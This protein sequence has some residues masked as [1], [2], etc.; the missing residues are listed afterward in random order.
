M[1]DILFSLKK[2]RRDLIGVLL[3]IICIA[4]SCYSIFTSKKEKEEIDSNLLSDLTPK[5]TEIEEEQE[6]VGEK[7]TSIYVDIKGAVNNPGVY[8]TKE[9]AIISDIIALAG[10]LTEDAYQ[11]GINLSKKVSDEMV[12][13]IYTQKEVA[14]KENE[15]S[16]TK[17]PTTSST[18]NT[19]SYNINDCVEKTESIIVPNSDS[20]K[21]EQ[22]EPADE[23]SGLINI[24]T[25]NKTKLTELSGIGDV[26]AQA[27]IDYRNTH[28][29]F[30]NIE[31]ILNV[32]GIGD[33][34][35]TKI[36]DY[37]TV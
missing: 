23:T 8:E 2:Y 18:C 26:K 35:F 28:G 37:I 14:E 31:D 12:I 15:T 21:T 1:Q 9:G 16:N 22:E 24:N 11:N 30:K 6:E 7:P 13:Y 20:E 3:V 33:A 25:A 32:N 29:Y 5:E 4:L 10:G 34:V 27:I 19:T 17:T 36:K